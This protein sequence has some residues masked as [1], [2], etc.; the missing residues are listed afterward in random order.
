VLANFLEGDR[1]TTIPVSR[2]K[3][4]LILRW[5]AGKF[6]ADVEYTEAQVNA[7]MKRHHEDAATLRREMVGCRMLA[8]AGGV[9]RLLAES[10]WRPSP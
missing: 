5:L 2:K 8:R 3:R 7:I 9:Y 10:E 4:W 1:L 6:S